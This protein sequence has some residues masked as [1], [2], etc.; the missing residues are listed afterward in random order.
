MRTGQH[1]WRELPGGLGRVRKLGAYFNN[2]LDLSKFFVRRVPHLTESYAAMRPWPTV[3]QSASPAI[4]KHPDE[5]RLRVS[6]ARGIQ[7]NTTTG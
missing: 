5:S 3:G 4:S 1:S 2:P 7:Q 6:R